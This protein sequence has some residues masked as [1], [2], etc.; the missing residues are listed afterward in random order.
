MVVELPSSLNTVVP[1][2]H[3]VQA[4]RPTRLSVPVSLRYSIEDA[5]GLE[6]RLIWMV[7]AYLDRSWFPVSVQRSSAIGHSL[8]RSVLSYRCNL[9]Q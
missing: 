2:K 9:Q 8:I 3:I 1:S 4:E 7:E 6:S 5:G